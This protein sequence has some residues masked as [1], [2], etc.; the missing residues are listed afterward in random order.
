MDLRLDF[1]SAGNYHSG[2]QIARVVT[3]A[4]VADNMFCPHCGRPHI[5]HFPNNRPVA[6][7]YCPDCLSEYEL[8]SK[9]GLL[10]REISD[11]A[12]DTMIERITS[13]KNPDFFF[14]SYSR[15][16]L[17][18]TD[19]MLIPKFFFVPEVIKKRKPLAATARRAGWT[20]CNIMLDAIPEQGRIKI[21]SE[22]VVAD[23]PEVLRQ[24]S[25]GMTL[26]LDNIDARGWLF[27]VLNCVNSLQE[28][29]F[30]LADVYAFDEKLQERHPQ[31]NN[32]R[33]K[34]RQ[35]LQML[36]DKGLI[37]FLGRGKYRKVL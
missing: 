25:R 34:M 19:L 23:A 15:E 22:G 11:G 26:K 30:S 9:N 6:D 20:G 32:V 28:E 1:L 31:N 7:F 18:V 8:K 35:Q 29:Y 10:G 2:S 27:D 4:W 13:S 5:E 37:E 16:K 17:C 24:V 3:E 14:M 21:I 33:A 12:Y 36:R